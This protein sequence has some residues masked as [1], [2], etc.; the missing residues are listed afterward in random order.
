MKVIRAPHPTLRQTA[1]A[2]T[3]VDKKL[4]QNVELLVESLLEEKDPE[5]VGLAFPQIDRSIRAFAYRPDKENQTKPE[6]VLVLFNPVITSHSQIQVLG[7]DPQE[8]DLEG[9]L[10]VPNL[11]APVPRWS[12]VKLQFQVIQDEK[13]V[14]RQQRFAGYQARIVQ[15]ELDHLD[16]ILFTDYVLKLN[17]PIYFQEGEKMVP[18]PDRNILKMY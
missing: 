18:M 10:S 13:L 11:Y 3:Q 17:L 15:H 6:D 14:D 2:I 5:G 7:E 8:P 4:L 16:G 12:W 9:C 1:Q